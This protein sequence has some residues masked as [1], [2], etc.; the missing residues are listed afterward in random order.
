MEALGAGCRES[1]ITFGLYGQ[2]GAL[3]EQNLRCG[4]VMP[5]ED[6][7]IDNFGTVRDLAGYPR[8]RDAVA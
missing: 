2:M 4:S 5:P 3:Q 7:T 8:R 1:G 6:M